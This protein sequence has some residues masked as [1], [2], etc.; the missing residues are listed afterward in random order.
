MPE[1]VSSSAGRPDPKRRGH[2]DHGRDDHGHDDYGH[3]DHGRDDHGHDD[4]GHDDHDDDGHDRGHD[5]HGHDDHDDDGHDRGHDDHGHDG[6]DHDDH[7]LRSASRRSL[8]VVLTLVAGYTFVELIGGLASGSLALVSDSAHMFTDA[9]AI[10]LALFSMWIAEREASA[11]RTFGYYRAEV[12]AALV[13]AISLWLIVG[14]ISLEAYN[15]F[16][17][18][19]EVNGAGALVIGAGGLVVNIVSALI[20]HRSARHSLNVEGAFQHV[21]ADLLGSVGVVVSS[22]LIIVFDWMLADL[23]VSVF[24]GLLIL[25]SSFRLI[26]RVVHVLLEGTPKHIDAYKLCSEIEDLDGVTLIHDVHVWT[27]TSGNEAFT[28]HV[29]VDPSY[30]GDMDL[31]L[32]RVQDIVHRNFGIGHATIQVEQSLKGCA[33]DHHVGHLLAAS[34]SD[35]S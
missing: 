26:S 32:T 34:A 23:I 25:V 24:I 13:N 8:I 7:G 9:A 35:A 11:E 18:G 2:S 1:A 29:L 3:D 30:E 33:E 17:E 4:H 20:L 12:L 31:L 19:T 16:T 22:I 14:W 27:I 28:A 10:V 6:H 21:M 15:R 5:D